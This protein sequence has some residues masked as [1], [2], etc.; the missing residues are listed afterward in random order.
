MDKNW[1]SGVVIRAT[2][3]FYFVRTGSRTVSCKVRGR[4]KQGRYSV[5]VGDNVA[6]SIS[7]EESGTIEEVLARDSFLKRPEVANVS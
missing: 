3:G 5:C 4:M 2:S 7:G 1:S 6:F